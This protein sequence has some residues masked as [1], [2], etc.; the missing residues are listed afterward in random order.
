MYFDPEK[1][2]HETGS[3]FFQPTLAEFEKVFG[4]FRHI[5][6]IYDNITDA[7]EFGG[8]VISCFKCEIH[9]IIRYHIAI[10]YRIFW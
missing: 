6:F 9:E 10:I 7:M 5:S 4:H 8:L 2:Q 1:L 3:R